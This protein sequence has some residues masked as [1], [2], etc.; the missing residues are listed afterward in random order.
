VVR[1]LSSRHVAEI[2]IETYSILSRID[3]VDFACP[4][5][6]YD[7]FFKRLCEQAK[8]LR[9]R[10]EMILYELRRVQELCARVNVSS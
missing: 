2:M 3:N 6:L 9:I 1:I 7:V 4:G 10:S 5:A 8:K